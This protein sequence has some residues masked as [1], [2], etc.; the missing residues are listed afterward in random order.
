MDKKTLPSWEL[1]EAAFEWGFA[2]VCGCDE[3]GP[4]LWRGRYMPGR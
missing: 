2:L 1:E 3:A 4:V